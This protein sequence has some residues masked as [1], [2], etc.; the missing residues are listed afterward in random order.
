[1][2]LRAYESGN[3]FRQRQM[4]DARPRSSAF[5]RRKE[6]GPL[7]S[8]Q[9]ALRP[10][11]AAHWAQANPSGWLWWRLAGSKSQS[12]RILSF[13]GSTM[14]FDAVDDV[15]PE[16]VPRFRVGALS[17]RLVVAY[18]ADGWRGPGPMGGGWSQDLGTCLEQQVKARCTDNI[19]LSRIKVRIQLVLREQTRLR[20]TSKVSD[21]ESREVHRRH[22]FSPFSAG[23]NV[24][25]TTNKQ[26]EPFHLSAHQP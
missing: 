20:D 8:G 22:Q 3:E 18:R 21:A 26:P 24:T 10:A 14:Q 12:E 25:T 16:R 9:T 19:L 2:R 5:K 23:R 6:R 11:G 17:G 4:Q 13:G 7:F 15:L 1:M